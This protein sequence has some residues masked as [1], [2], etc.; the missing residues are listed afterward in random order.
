MVD[1]AVLIS[2]EAELQFTR[3][4]SEDA[5]NLGL[6]LLNNAKDYTRPIVIDINLAG[7]QLFHYSMQ[8][9]SPDNN[10]WIRRKNNTVKR[11]GHSSFYM[12]QY[13]ASKSAVFEQ[14][15]A[16]SDKEYACHGGAFPLIIQGVGIVGTVTVSGLAQEDDHALVVSSIKE[17]LEKQ[18]EDA[19]P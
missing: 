7:H 19:K 18:L 3:F 12:G 5:L 9:T 2:Q 1:L 8:G 13:C 6:L 10:E 15:Y 14:K 11:F 16:V 17:Y 4:S